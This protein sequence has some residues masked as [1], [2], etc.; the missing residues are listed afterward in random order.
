MDRGD[1]SYVGGT[2]NYMQSDSTSACNNGDNSIEVL[3]T[4][5][6]QVKDMIYYLENDDI[7]RPRFIGMVQAIDTANSE[8]DLF[9]AY[10][11]S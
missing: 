3:D 7:K 5:V 1:R 6:Y 11:G 10:A 2:F 9:S 4:S 8:L